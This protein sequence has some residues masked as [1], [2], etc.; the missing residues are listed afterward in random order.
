MEDDLE[1]ASLA[2]AILAVRGAAACGRELER[3]REHEGSDRKN[4]RVA[5]HRSPPRLMSLRGA[6]LDY[7]TRAPGGAFPRACRKM[8]AGAP[9]DSRS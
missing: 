1:D 2:A 8:S 7:K 9:H 4:D 5:H 3:D 6:L